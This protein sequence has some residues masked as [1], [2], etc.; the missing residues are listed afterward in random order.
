MKVTE[1]QEMGFNPR[2]Y[3]RYDANATVCNYLSIS[4]NPRTYIRYDVLWQNKL[5]V[6]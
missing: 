1:F 2:T 6:A 5:P 4:F 3:I